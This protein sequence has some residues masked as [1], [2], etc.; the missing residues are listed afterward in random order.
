MSMFKDQV[1][2]DIYK[3]FLNADEFAEEHRVE[4][5][6]IRVVIDDDQLQELKKGQILGMVEADML[7]FAKTSDLPTDPRPGQL[8]N[9]DGREMIA[10]DSGKA[11]GMTELA[12]RQNRTG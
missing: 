11:M 4:G 5:V 1:A 3:V 8:I 2:N 9:V 6:R 10:V 7:L 12:L